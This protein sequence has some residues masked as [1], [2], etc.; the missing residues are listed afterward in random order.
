MSRTGSS[1][2]PIESRFISCSCANRWDPGF[3]TS[4]TNLGPTLRSFLSTY[5]T[6]LEVKSF[7]L[8]TPTSAHQFTLSKLAQNVDRQ[9]ARRRLLLA[10]DPGRVLRLL[11]ACFHQ[12]YFI[13]YKL[14]GVAA[15]SS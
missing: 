10:N 8:L 14:L 4:T 5:F 7:S 6:R 12:N 11:G 15:I 1:G 13:R 2:P 3:S 9:L